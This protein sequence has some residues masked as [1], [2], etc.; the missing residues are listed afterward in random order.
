M[1]VAL[2]R[3]NSP[4]IHFLFGGSLRLPASKGHVN[5][6]VQNDVRAKIVTMVP[7]PLQRA[8]LHQEEFVCVVSANSFKGSRLTLKQYVEG[9]HISVNTLS[10]SQT[11]PDDRLAALG[12]QRRV[13]G[14][15]RTSPPRFNPSPAPS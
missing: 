14:G 9:S 6:Q 15:C 8:Q 5:A 10:G 3:A 12:H 1:L 11:L 4:S 13:V 7:S 2:R